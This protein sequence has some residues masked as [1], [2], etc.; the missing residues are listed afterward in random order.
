[1]LIVALAVVS[2]AG[3]QLAAGHVLSLPFSFVLPASSRLFKSRF[4][5]HQSIIT[6]TL[7]ASALTR[8]SPSRTRCSVTPERSSTTSPS[9]TK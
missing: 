6:T 9:S 2:A 1:M 7:S 3:V 8:N 5:H 4:H